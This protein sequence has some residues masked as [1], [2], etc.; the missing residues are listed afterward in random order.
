MWSVESCQPCSG[1]GWQIHLMQFSNKFLKR[2]EAHLLTWFSLNSWYFR[3][4]LS[5]SPI[6][7][8]TCFVFFQYRGV[9]TKMAVYSWSGFKSCAVVQQLVS[10][11]I[12]AQTS[13]VFSWTSKLHV[14]WGRRVWFIVNLSC[15]CKKNFAILAGVTLRTFHGQY[16]RLKKKIQMQ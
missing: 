11:S 15:T 9:T 2:P 14:P 4:V 5:S 3:S 1:D 12:F 13:L 10:N 16:V 6:E 8:C 7:I